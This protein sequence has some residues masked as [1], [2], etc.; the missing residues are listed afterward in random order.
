MKNF[1]RSTCF[2]SSLARVSAGNKESISLRSSNSDRV[3]LQRPTVM[4][5][6][7]NPL[8]LLPSTRLRA[9]CCQ[10]VA[11]ENGVPYQMD[12]SA[13]EA[14]VDLPSGDRL[15]GSA[16][17]AFFLCADERGLLR[18]SAAKDPADVAAARAQVLQ[19]LFRCESELW[20]VLSG[21]VLSSLNLA[22]SSSSSPDAACR[23]I[24]ELDAYLAS[25]TY[26]ACDRLSVADFC[27]CVPVALVARH[28]REVASEVGAALSGARHLRR[29]LKLI[30]AQAA[31][32]KVL[33]D[34][35]LLLAEESG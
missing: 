24:E 6:K 22:N 4:S 23:L 9:L 32:K 27:S 12:G 2:A 29:W 26:L 11:E 31:V 17:V 33:G 19:W 25:R 30:L 21:N 13:D 34:V 18:P 5:A 1:V 7:S 14:A 35:D 20:P 16:A 3:S 28:K 15:V 8:L 10:M